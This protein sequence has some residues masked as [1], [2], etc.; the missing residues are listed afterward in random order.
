MNRKPG[1]SDVMY[2]GPKLVEF[3]RSKGVT[4]AGLP[5]NMDRAMRRWR[6]GERATERMVDE[7]CC[8][9]GWGSHMTAVPHSF[10][11]KGRKLVDPNYR[12]KKA[13]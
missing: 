5:P 13:A 10:I 12:G 3:L 6:D 2:H 8:H 11:V 4:A 7:L 1:E 9:L